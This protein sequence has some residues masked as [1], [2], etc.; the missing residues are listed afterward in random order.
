MK[1]KNYRYFLISIFLTTSLMLI[2]KYNILEGVKDS[3]IP[4]SLFEEKVKNY[5]CDKAGSRLTNK[6][7]NGYTEKDPKSKSLSKAQRSIVDF[8]KDSSYSNIKPY[9]KKLGIFIF[10]LVLDIILI[11][12]WISYCSCCCCSCCLFSSAKPSKLCRTIFF[13]IA[14]ICNL[15]V[16]IFSIVVL[17]LINPFFKRVNGFVCSAYNF[18]DHV[19]YGLAPSY[20]NNQKEWGGI[21][22]I[23]NLLNYTEIGKDNIE[24]TLDT[25]TSNISPYKSGQCKEFLVLDSYT[26]SIKDLV[27]ESFSDMEFENEINDLKDAKK[28]FDDADEDIGDDAYDVLHDYI[29]KL[30]KKICTLIFTLTLIFGIL[31][32]AFLCLYFF[33]KYNVFRIVYVVIW[34]ISMLLMLFAILFAVVFGILGYVL[35]DAVQVSQYILSPENLDSDDPLLFDSDKNKNDYGDNGNYDD[36]DEKDIS[37]TD[38][39]DECANGDGNFMDL[40]QENGQLRENIENWE[41]N[42]SIYRDKINN[43]DDPSCTESEKAVLRDN[44]EKLI[45]VTSVGLNISNNLTSLKCRFARNDKNIILNEVDSAGKKGVALCACSLLV[46]I[47]LGISVVAGIIFAHKYKYDDSPTNAQKDLNSTT[48]VNESSENIRNDNTKNNNNAYN[49]PKSDMNYPY[50]NTNYPTNMVTN[51]NMNL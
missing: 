29:N 5:A 2:K 44:Y 48:E 42:Q 4:R 21:D 22:G 37:V 19:R 15:L 23:I 8:A 18:I 26:N 50:N 11:F 43:I 14:A 32:L 28:T 38:L 51:N 46:G 33:L 41:K 6:Y 35:R 39:I 13:L 17:G 27:N 47:L 16:I 34:N 24:E 3:I 40:L 49:I 25:I 45:D 10:F 7:S 31:G 9:I 1:I 20:P 12:V 36:D 30:A